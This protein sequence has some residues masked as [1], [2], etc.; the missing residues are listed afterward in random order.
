MCEKD[1]VRSFRLSKFDC[2]IAGLVSPSMLLGLDP[3]PLAGATQEDSDPKIDANS[4]IIAVHYAKTV[5][6]SR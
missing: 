6:L 5:P 1:V 3:S 2:H 4:R